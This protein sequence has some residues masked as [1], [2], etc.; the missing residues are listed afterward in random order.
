MTPDREASLPG[1]SPPRLTSELAGPVELELE[2]ARA[3]DKLPGRNALPGGSR[4]QLKYDGYL[5]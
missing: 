4:Y 1:E 3:V 2:L 5:H